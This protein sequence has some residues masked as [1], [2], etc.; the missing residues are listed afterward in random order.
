MADHQ[1]SFFNSLKNFFMIII[2]GLLVS[3][4]TAIDNETQTPFPTISSTQ[5]P[6]PTPPPTPTTQKVYLL[7]SDQTPQTIV[8]TVFSTLIELSQLHGLEVLSA[9]G[10]STIEFEPGTRIVV[11]LPPDPGIEALSAEN[12]DIQFLAIGISGL[13]PTS[14]L[15]II[16]PEGIRE[17]RVAFTAGFLAAVLT[18]DFRIGMLNQASSDPGQIITQSFTNG[19]VYYCGLCR[20]TYPPFHN[21]P[22]LYEFP[23][24]PTDNDWENA[25]NHLLSFSVRTVYISM[26][27]LDSSTVD[28]LAQSELILL[29]NQTPPP[30]LEN[31][32]IATLCISPEKILAAR[33]ND[34][35]SNQGGWVEEIPIQLENI[36]EDLFSVGKQNWVDEMLNDLVGGFIDTGYSP[37]SGNP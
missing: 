25:I 33:W 36:N 12:P 21:Y 31:S 10:S 19:M 32:W 26:D 2:V 20:M 8:Q 30:G 37:E 28:L 3:C 18:K 29:G 14:N 24:H 5:T 22:I 6:S 7:A 9:E 11:V 16:G 17:D 35:I 4:Q 23:D 34:L 1:S 13:L 15:S 27:N